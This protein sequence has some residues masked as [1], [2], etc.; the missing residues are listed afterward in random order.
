MLK[1]TVWIL[2][3]IACITGPVRAQTLPTLRAHSRLLDIRDGER[4]WKGI[5]VAAPTMDPD[6][7]VASRSTRAKTITFIS[8]LDSLSID[9]EPGHTYDIV[10]VLDDRDACR[11]RISTMALGCANANGSADSATIPIRIAHGKLHLDGFVNDSATLDLIFDTGADTNVLYP[12]AATKGATIA[13]DGTSLNSGTGGTTARTTSSDN[14]IRV[15]ALRWDHE[16]VML[17]EKQADDADGILGYRAFDNKIVEFDY[18]RMV[19]VIHDELPASLEGYAQTP[20]VPVGSLTAIEARLAGDD[21][22]ARGLFVLDSAGTGAMMMNAA[23]ASSA[24][25]RGAWKHVGSSVSGG[26]G[27]GTMRNDVVIV[28]RVT[29][30]NF[31]LVDMP[32]DMEV[33]AG[34]ATT[35]TDPARGAGVLCMDVLRRFN[36]VLDYERGVAYLK[37]STHFATPFPERASRPALVVTIGIAAIAL[38]GAIVTIVRRRRNSAAI[39]R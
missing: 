4:L 25:L 11:T 14:R 2:V 5:W 33:H 31:T 23:F 26:V 39:K 6:I 22:D 1:H 12:S 35:A 29:I 15:G 18:D 24:S 9:V 13:I 20:L 32:L 34:S 30:A 27:A 21:K 16:P 19:M 8:D 3:V 37:P 7:Y 36:T 38:V 28:P 10:V 17:I